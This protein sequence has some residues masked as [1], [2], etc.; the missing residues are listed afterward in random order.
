MWSLFSHFGYTHSTDGT[1]YKTALPSRP[2]FPVG[3]AIQHAAYG[4]AYGS[5]FRSTGRQGGVC[6]YCYFFP[7]HAPGAGDRADV[8]CRLNAPESLQPGWTSLLGA[9]ETAPAQ[10]PSYLTVD[11]VERE[12]REEGECDGSWTC[13]IRLGEGH[14]VEQGSPEAWL[15][16]WRPRC[17]Q[18]R[19][20]R[21][22]DAAPSGLPAHQ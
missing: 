14:S 15:D 8:I 5:A 18:G 22:G 6:C 21:D 10:H 3:P 9:H 19:D 11:A 12:G 2:S 4:R 13:T 1:I 17:S 7:C 20:S 16:F